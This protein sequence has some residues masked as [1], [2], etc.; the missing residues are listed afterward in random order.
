[1]VLFRTHFAQPAPPVI[2]G[3]K[4]CIVMPAYN[5]EKTLEQTYAAL[6][7]EL[8]DAVIVV[9]DA[10]QDHTAELAQ[11]L[12]GVRVIRHPQNLGYGGNQKTCYAN[13]LALNA[14]VVVMVHP[15]YQYAPELCAAMASMIAYGTYDCVLG[16]RILGSTAL[17]GGMPFYKYVANRALTLFQNVLLGSKLSEYHTGFRAFSRT[18]IES[19]PLA[20]NSDDFVF[21][22]QMLIQIIHGG[23]RIGELSCPTR[24]TPDSSSISFAR[25]V[26]YGLGVVAMTLVYLLS[27]WGL[28]RLP[29]YSEVRMRQQ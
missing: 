4:I 7:A 20:H 24:Y 25:S 23:F 26:R 12:P 15:D 11:R 3:K 28:W 14:D 10:S 2:N 18:L 22:N 29:L 16:S 8:I 1:M 13:A 19:L 21:D 5:A 6:P 27:R 17:R 9:D